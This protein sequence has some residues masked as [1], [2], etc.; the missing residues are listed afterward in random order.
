LKDAIIILQTV[1]HIYACTSPGTIP[2][3]TGGVEIKTA[4][5]RKVFAS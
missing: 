4:A 5:K 3:F 2:G 1:T